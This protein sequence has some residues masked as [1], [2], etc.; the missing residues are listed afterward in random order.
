MYAAILGQVFRRWGIYKAEL[1]ATLGTIERLIGCHSLFSAVER[2]FSMRQ[3][4]SFGAAIVIVWLLSP[5]G[6]QSSLRL[7]STQPFTRPETNS[8]TYFPIEA[9]PMATL[10]NTDGDASRLWSL[11]ALPYI[12]A[13]QQRYD[14]VPK[15]QLESGDLYTGDIRNAEDFPTYHAG[16]P[17]YNWHY[18]ERPQDFV[19]TSRINKGI[20]ILRSYMSGN[21][22]FNTIR[23]YWAVECDAPKY[24]ETFGTWSFAT[25]NSTRIGATGVFPTFQLVVD[26]DQSTSNNVSFAYH[27]RRNSDI[28]NANVTTTHCQARALVVETNFICNLDFSSTESGC[29]VNAMRVIN[30][31]QVFGPTTTPLD[32]FRR[33]SSIMP[34]VDL[35]RPDVPPTGSQITE[36]YIGNRLW[37][38]ETS[39]FDLARLKKEDLSKNLQNAINTFWFSSIGDVTSQGQAADVSQQSLCDEAAGRSCTD[40]DGLGWNSTTIAGETMASEEYIYNI[41][42]A[43]VMI[44]ISLFL[45]VT[46]ILSTVLVLKILA[47]DILGYVSTAVRDSP[48]FQSKEHVLSSMSG[49]QAARRLRDV[50][51]KIADVNRQGGLGHV[52]LTT[53]IDG[54]DSLSRKR[55]YD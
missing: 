40:T 29:W 13:L 54:S 27:S 17:D 22:S 23:H 55:M 26:A 20:P 7:L 33:I 18:R 38:R 8:L 15:Q 46:S 42:F 10:I 52:A 1:S 25:N 4:D 36:L 9:Y 43:I 3:L 50:R 51:V 39:W 12:Q 6:G 53:M 30:R 16:T 45:L 41:G 32:M 5:I 31:D 21:S 37:T 24:N 35:L 48:Y 2:Q 19:L 47:P 34:Y 28:E 14:N 49:L 44:I 11:Y